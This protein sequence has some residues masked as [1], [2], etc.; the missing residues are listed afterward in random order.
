MFCLFK[1]LFDFKQFVDFN[2]LCLKRKINFEKLVDKT[3]QN[4]NTIQKSIS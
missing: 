4:R 2:K 3:I 1:K